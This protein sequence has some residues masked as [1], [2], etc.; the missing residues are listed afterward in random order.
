[1][2]I[3]LMCPNCRAVL[4]IES[5]DGI[6]EKSVEC[7]HCHAKKMIRQFLPKLSMKVGEKNYQLRFGRQWVGR[8]KVGNDAEIQIPDETR[9]MSKKHALVEV[10]CSAKGILC[11]FEEHGKNPTSIQGISLITDDIVYLSINDCLTLG[12]KNMYLA[13]E[14]RE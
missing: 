7:P 12:S 5:S 14:Y 13:N 2:K 3:N 6:E 1:M 4:M 11:T 8:E 9:Y 10:K